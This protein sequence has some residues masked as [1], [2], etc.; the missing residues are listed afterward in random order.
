MNIFKIFDFFFTENSHTRF[1]VTAHQLKDQVLGPLMDTGTKR[2]LKDLKD[3]TEPGSNAGVHGIFVSDT[4]S[5]ATLQ[6][7]SE[8]PHVTGSGETERSKN[9]E[10]VNLLEDDNFI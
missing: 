6:P 9:I 3:S 10:P 8:A 7:V 2:N 5:C 4:P 1:P